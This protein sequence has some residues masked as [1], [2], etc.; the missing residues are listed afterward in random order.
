MPNIN[1]ELPNEKLL[2]DLYFWLHVDEEKASDNWNGP[3]FPRKKSDITE[4]EFIKKQTEPTY[5]L[6]SIPKQMVITIDGEFLGTLHAYWES[7]VT[8]WMEIGICIF[9]KHYWGKGLGTIALQLWV[10]YIF[11]HST[12]HRIGLTTWSGN[13]R[14]IKSAAKVGM[15]EEARIRRARIVKGE[16]YDSIKMGMLREEWEALR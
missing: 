7:E 3:Y 2:S 15:I 10:D 14:M 1:I 16:Y 5:L 12:L 4:D 9:N 6:E 8:N 11:E 13:Y